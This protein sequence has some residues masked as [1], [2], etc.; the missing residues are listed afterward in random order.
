VP[1]SSPAIAAV[2]ENH[3]GKETLRAC[4][5]SL[6]LQEQKHTVIVVENGS[7]DGSLEYIRKNYPKKGKTNCCVAKI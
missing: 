3:N 5:N 7:T 1:K 2:I 4:L 6:V